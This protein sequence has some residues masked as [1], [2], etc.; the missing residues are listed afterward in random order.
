MT[1]SKQ[2]ENL[3]NRKFLRPSDVAE[4]YGIHRSTIFRWIKTG[5]L[6][7]PKRLTPRIMGW[8]RETLD[9]I[10]LKQAT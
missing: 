2:K 7:E 10:F 6:P 9:E 3:G 1:T 5:K 4:I 8:D